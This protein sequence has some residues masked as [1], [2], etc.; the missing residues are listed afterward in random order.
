MIFFGF[1]TTSHPFDI[2]HNHL[3]QCYYNHTH[4]SSFNKNNLIAKSEAFIPLPL[5]NQ[6]FHLQVNSKIA[7]S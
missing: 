3:I 4:Y 5:L 1:I 6:G 7:L 2:T